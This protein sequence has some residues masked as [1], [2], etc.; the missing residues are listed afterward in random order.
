MVTVGIL[1]GAFNPPHKEHIRICKDILKEFCL[2]KIYFVPTKDAPHKETTISFDMRSKMVELVLLNERNLELDTIE[3][4]IE[5]TTYSVKVLKELKAKYKNIAFIIGGDSMENFSK[6]ERPD[7]IIKTCPIIV[8]PRGEIKDKLISSV[9]QYNLKGGSIKLSNAIGEKISSSLIRARIELGLDTEEYLNKNCRKF[10]DDNGLYKSYKDMIA[11]LKTLI[12]PERFIHT[13]D[14]VLTALKLNDTW[15]VDYD[16]VFTAALL[17]DCMKDSTFIHEGVPKDTY[18]TLVLH[19][20]NGAIEAKNNFGIND[21]DILNAIRYHTTCRPNMSKLEKLIYLADMIEPSRVY[22][23]VD[24]I[25]DIASMDAEQG[26]LSA[27]K[28]AYKH[29]TNTIKNIYPLTTE[30]YKYYFKGETH[31]I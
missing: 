11:K 7:E 27:F 30:A 3:E 14:T 16:K 1:G 2:D 31:D 26:F 6:W 17:H 21:E 28:S 12:T 18:D 15:G 24:E 5:G 8:V 19:A 4:S 29:I 13:V 10:I 20:F 22:P 9:H 23:D 25:R